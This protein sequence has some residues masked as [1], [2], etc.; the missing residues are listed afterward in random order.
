MRFR[1]EAGCHGVVL[2]R[3]RFIP[4][5][6]AGVIAKRPTPEGMGLELGLPGRRN[7]AREHGHKRDH[8]GLLADHEVDDEGKNTPQEGIAPAVRPLPAA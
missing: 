2:Y 4:D 8:I 6:S 1:L 3:R 5:R 7:Q